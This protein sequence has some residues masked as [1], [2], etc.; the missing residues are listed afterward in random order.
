MAKIPNNIIKKIERHNALVERAAKLEDEID[1][2]YK[3]QYE[4]YNGDSSDISDEE[5][6]DIKCD[7]SATYVSVENT[8]YNLALLAPGVRG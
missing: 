6:A 7:I 5:F 4:K 1:E 3:K 8:L 2:W